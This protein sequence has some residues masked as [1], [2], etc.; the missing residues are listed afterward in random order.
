MEEVVITISNKETGK[1]YKARSYPDDDYNNN[2]KIELYETPI[3]KVFIDSVLGRKEWKATRFMPYWNDP[4]NPSRNYSYR[5]WTSSGL[6]DAVNK[7]IITYYDRNYVIHNTES[8]YYGAIQIESNFLIHAGPLNHENIG[9]GGAGCVEIIGDFNRFKA[10]IMDLAGI[11][12]GNTDDA[13]TNLVRARKLFVTI[14]R[15]IRPNLKKNFVGE[16]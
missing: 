4:N 2:G 11:R 3:Y 8:S 14:E 7:R 9:W 15:A 10:D 16:F 1:K 13:I 6:S 12:S 5:G